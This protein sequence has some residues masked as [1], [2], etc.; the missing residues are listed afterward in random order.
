MWDAFTSFGGQEEGIMLESLSAH[1]Q[2]MIS[3]VLGRPDV[4]AAHLTDKPS[5]MLFLSLNHRKLYISNSAQNSGVELFV[6]HVLV[7]HVPESHVP[8]SPSPTSLHP[9]LPRVPCPGVS[10][11]SSPG[12]SRPRLTFSHSRILLPLCSHYSPA[13]VTDVKIPT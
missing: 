6:Y 12:V 11:S 7:S 5:I 13:F 4:F 2:L 9:P 3:S 8:A 10:E 1:Q